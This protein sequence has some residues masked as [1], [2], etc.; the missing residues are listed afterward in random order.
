MFI[1]NLLQDMNMI[2]SGSSQQISGGSG[3]TVDR[4]GVYGACYFIDQSEYSS[5][6]Q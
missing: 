2:Q 6:I 5:V 1:N 4:M 3:Q